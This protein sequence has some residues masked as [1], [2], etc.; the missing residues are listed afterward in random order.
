[1]KTLF[2]SMKKMDVSANDK[3]IGICPLISVLNF[4]FEVYW[5][6]SQKTNGNHH[7][8]ERFTKKL[9]WK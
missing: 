2:E 8:V 3:D 7:F 1:M 4:S 9:G 5:L 6:L